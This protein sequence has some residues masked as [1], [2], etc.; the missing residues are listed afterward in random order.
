MSAGF[1]ISRAN[2][3]RSIKRSKYRAIRTEFNGIWFASKKEA[4]R[5][6]EL[7]L[8]EKAGEITHLILQPRYPLFTWRAGECVEVC[9]YR[10]DFSYRTKGGQQIVEDVKGIDTPASKL[11]RKWLKLQSNIDVVLT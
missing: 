1:A 9:V 10:G 5:Y 3:V 8:L 11:K 6:A 2:V 7:S 4:R